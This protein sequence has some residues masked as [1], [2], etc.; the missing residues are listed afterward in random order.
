MADG[1]QPALGGELGKRRRLVVSALRQALDRLVVEHVDPAADPDGK[2]R[3]LAEAG[4]DVLLVELDEPEGALRADDGDRRGG[5]ALA[6]PLEKGAE[7][8]VDELVAVQREYRPVLFPQPRRVAEPAS[9][10]QTLLLGRRD[11]LRAEAIELALE[12]RLFPAEQL[13]IRR[14]TPAAASCRPGRR[15]GGGRPRDERLRPSA[16][17][18]AEPFGLAAREDERLGHEMPGFRI[19]YQPISTV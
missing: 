4:D 17:G 3:V 8:D 10:P 15:S 14:S 18:V 5:A 1:V 19:R 12:Q 13:T 6:V 16:G 11:D 2:V 7:I 9:A